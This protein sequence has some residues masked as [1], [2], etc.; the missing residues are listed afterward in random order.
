M[1]A[2]TLDI[3][4]PC[5]TP[6]DAEI[7]AWKKLSREEQIRLTKHVLDHPNCEKP[8]TLTMADIAGK[9]S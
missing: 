3:V 1:K 2:E 7:L 4:Y 5:A 8:S 6:T 9:N